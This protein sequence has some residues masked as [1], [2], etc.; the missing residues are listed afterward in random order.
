MDDSPKTLKK[1]RKHQTQS[2]FYGGTR[3]PVPHLRDAVVGGAIGLVEDD[4][5][6]SSRGCRN[7]GFEGLGFNDEA[8][9]FRRTFGRGSR[10]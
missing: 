7:W 8:I 10:G 1:S 5:G 2:R 9:G 6:G 3:I 4:G